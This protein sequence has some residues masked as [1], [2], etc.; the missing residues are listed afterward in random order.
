MKDNKYKN[1]P[2]ILVLAPRFPSF[3]QPWMDTYLEQL[4]KNGLDFNIIST[5]FNNNKCHEKVYRLGLLEHTRFM[6]I[7]H[8]QVLK[9]FSLSVLLRPLQVLFLFICSVKNFSVNNSP[10]SDVKFAFRA[11][12]CSYTVKHLKSLK[13]IHT[14]SDWF[15]LYFLPISLYYKIPMILTLHGLLPNGLEQLSL[16]KRQLLFKYIS[17]VLVNTNASKQQV[18][19][20]GCPRE[21][22][23]VLPQ[24][25]P[26][27]DFPFK[28]RSAP[29]KNEPIKLLTIGRFHKDKGQIYAILALKRLLKIGIDACWTFVGT[30]PEKARL[31]N[32]AEKLR[33]D[34]KIM[35]LSDLDLSSIQKLY[36]E[37]HLFVLPSLNNRNHNEPVETQGVVLQEAQAS[38]CIP[39][40]TRVGGIPECV[41]DKKDGIL[42][43]DRS[44][45]A[46]V[47]AV[48]YL[49]ERPELWELYQ[50]KGRQNVENKFSAGKIGKRMAELI[51]ELMIDQK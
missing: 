9:A 27:E 8:M 28:P 19:A 15:G 43:K 32:L 38:G 33:I 49:M 35:F 13:V 41:N 25:L 2:E 6:H 48:C 3:N 14:H 50:I 16:V 22:I 10:I 17:S 34:S 23:I 45:R 26:L 36:Q 4:K 47:E 29:K 31:L 37:C 1:K 5:N 42:I 21:K 12:Q 7:S 18:T 44:C 51:S 30:G 11:I 46:I 39:I 20:L 40:A 24:G